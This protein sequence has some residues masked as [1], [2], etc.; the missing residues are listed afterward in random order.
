M[1]RRMTDGLTGPEALEPDI[2]LHESEP[3]VAEHAEVGARVAQA[4]RRAGMTGS[5]LGAAVGLRKDQISKIESGKRRLDIGE[6]PDIAAALGVTVRYLLAR[7]STQ[8]SCPWGRHE[9]V[10]TGSAGCRHRLADLGRSAILRSGGSGQGMATL[11]SRCATDRYIEWCRC[12]EF[13]PG[14]WSGRSRAV[15]RLGPAPAGCGK[16][17]ESASFSCGFARQVHDCVA[18]SP[19]LARATSLRSW[20]LA[21]PDSFAILW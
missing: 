13:V 6:L 7:I 11:S 9:G 19:I 14:R 3:V 17:A 18:L 21:V 4:R 10:K 16:I 20:K 12:G 2:A 8:P 1:E 5:Q 15:R